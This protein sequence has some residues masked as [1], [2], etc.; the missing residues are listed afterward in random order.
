[1]ANENI[2]D[3]LSK[4][5]SLRAGLSIIAD[6]KDSYYC[7]EREADNKIKGYTFE[8]KNIERKQKRIAQTD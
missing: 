5:Y 3:T 7:I 4:L 6:E 2:T 8:Q 1:M